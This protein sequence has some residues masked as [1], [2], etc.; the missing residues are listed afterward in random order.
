MQL[1]YF[2]CWIQWYIRPRVG[3]SSSSLPTPGVII[4]LPA[5]AAMVWCSSF[6]SLENGE[7][8][9]RH[10][11][12]TSLI[13]LEIFAILHILRYPSEIFEILH[14]HAV[15]FCLFLFIF[16]SIHSL[17]YTWRYLGQSAE[18]TKQTRGEVEIRRRCIVGWISPVAHAL[19]K[20]KMPR[21]CK[22][23]NPCSSQPKTYFQFLIHLDSKQDALASVRCKKTVWVLH[24]SQPFFSTTAVT[25]RS[26]NWQPGHD[27]YHRAIVL[28]PPPAPINAITTDS[29]RLIHL[30]WHEMTFARAT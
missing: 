22:Q 19:W 10:R 21:L 20:T 16:V 4:V 9:L 29:Y 15:G 2:R 25:V 12:L 28:Q 27:I 3:T 17:V 1:W 30:K 8:H 5:C 24:I 23:S 11:H 6:H 13:P 7:T 14:L 18:T 26:Y